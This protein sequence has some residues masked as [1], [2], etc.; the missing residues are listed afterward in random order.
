MKWT[1]F[2]IGATLAIAGAAKAQPAAPGHYLYEWNGGQTAGGSAILV[3]YDLRVGPGSCT[4][5]MQGF[6]TDEPSSAKPA[7]PPMA[8]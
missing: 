6:Q 2:C 4:L 3:R 5:A 7:A 1:A 8:C